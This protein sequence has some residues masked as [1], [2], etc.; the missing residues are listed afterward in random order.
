MLIDHAAL[1][2][3]IYEIRERSGVSQK[4]LAAAISVSQPTL[5]R[6]ES[7]DRAL[8]GDELI[9]LADALGVRVGAITAAHRIDERVQ[10][11]ARTDGSLPD[12]A[13]LRRHLVAYLEL[14][15]YLAN[16]SIPSA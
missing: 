15:E 6:I 13:G 9:L 1:G 11:A 4:E 14:D 10:V 3:R 5:S 8:A 12:M 7:G 2:R 16:H